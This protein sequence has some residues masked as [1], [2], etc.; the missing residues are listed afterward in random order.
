MRGQRGPGDRREIALPDALIDARA[1]D[2]EAVDPDI[3]APV[4]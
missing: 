1:W 2:V 4:P 3:L